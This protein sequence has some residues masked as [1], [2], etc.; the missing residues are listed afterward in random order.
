MRT[1]LPFRHREDLWRHAFGKRRK[2][3]LVVEFGVWKGVSL[4]YLA[5]MTNEV[6]YGFD[7]FEG[8]KEDWRGRGL[9]KGTFDTSG[10]VPKV[11]PN[12]R[13]VK[14][15]FDATLPRFMNEH[16]LMFSFVH[17]DC[18]TYEATSTILSLAGSR[19]IAGT[20]VVFDEYF[21]HRGWRMGEFKAWQDFGNQRGLSYEYLG[22]SRE[23]VSLVIQ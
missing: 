2:E 11:K 19:F 3:G 16:P 6:V 8:L 18:D 21:G 9:P 20:V 12:A 5:T 13:L 22:F 23:Q 10:T 4:N 1:A 15:W 7:S 14:G 17:F